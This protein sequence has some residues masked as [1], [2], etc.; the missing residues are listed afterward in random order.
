MGPS[1]YATGAAANSIAATVTLR[2]RIRK[3]VVFSDSVSEFDIIG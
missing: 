2:K 3:H 1:A